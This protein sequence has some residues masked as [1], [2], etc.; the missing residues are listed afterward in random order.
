MSGTCNSSKVCVSGIGNVLP[1][2]EKFAF[3]NLSLMMLP[4]L[5]DASCG[6]R[7]VE[8]N[9]PLLCS[10]MPLFY[11]VKGTPSGSSLARK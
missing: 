7:V 10:E 3:S 9:E 8:T 1:A 5:S 6:A 4:S 11:S 2:N